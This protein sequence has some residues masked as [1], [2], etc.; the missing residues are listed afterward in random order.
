MGGRTLDQFR[1]IRQAKAKNQRQTE[2]S[3]KSPNSR[4][5]NNQPQN[6]DRE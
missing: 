3:P 4:Q 1:S 2:Q 5:Q 6:S